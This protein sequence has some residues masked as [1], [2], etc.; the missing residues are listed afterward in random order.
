[1]AT[2][3]D[4]VTEALGEIKSDMQS[5]ILTFEIIQRDFD[6][7]RLGK[8]IPSEQITKIMSS[9]QGYLSN[10]SHG[11]NALNAKEI[12][13]AYRVKHPEVTDSVSL[14]EDEISKVIVEINDQIEKKFDDVTKELI[15]CSEHDSLQCLA[16]YVE[17]MR[18]IRDD[19]KT[20]RE[21]IASLKQRRKN[22]DKE[23]NE[24]K[25]AGLLIVKVQSM[26]KPLERCFAFVLRSF[27]K[28]RK[29]IMAEV[30][31]T[32]L[33]VE[34]MFDETSTEFKELIPSESNEFTISSALRELT[35]ISRR[36]VET[37]RVNVL[38]KTGNMSA[39]ERRKILNGLKKTST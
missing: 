3:L 36:H 25:N 23:S 27:F 2:I 38:V 13:T 35:E 19:M 18:S 7:L 37:H 12:I 10:V 16:D 31:R 28:K 6:A 14:S 22:L 17:I 8:R 33:A 15:F 32:T 30:W 24:Q 1:M 5:V 20:R 4:K 39:L 9:I 34:S 29:R 26:L 11:I 21:R